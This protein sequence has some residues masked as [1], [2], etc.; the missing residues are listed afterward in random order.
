[1][2]KLISALKAHPTESRTGFQ[3]R[4]SDDLAPRCAGL[5]GVKKLTLN[6][7]GEAPSFVTL[8]PPNPMAP[9]ASDAI[10]MAWLNERAFS[11]YES[12]FFEFAGTVHHYLVD[13][14][15]ARDEIP[16]VQG[17]MTEGIKNIP[18]IV[19]QK[20][21]DDAAR[22]DKWR[23]HAEL[24]LRIHTGM[25]RYVRNI[26]KEALTADAALVHAIGEVCFPTLDDLRYRQFPNPE[27]RQAFLDDIAGWVEA[28]TSHYAKEY[29]LKW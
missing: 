8:P 24:G 20:Q 26:V 29:V 3:G 14:I 1:M 2:A 4:V 16:L 19:A 5:A 6:I 10:M 12:E 25:R 7:V 27:D 18:F 15:I 9:P 23:V 11:D 22:R 21:H 17:Q 13:E 28:S